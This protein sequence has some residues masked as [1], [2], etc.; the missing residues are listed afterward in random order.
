M[1]D[2]ASISAALGSAKTILDLLKNA[3]DAQLA[4]RISSEIANVQGKLIDVQQQALDLQQ[5][6]HQLRGEIERSRS[7]RQHH[8]VI[9]KLLREGE[10]DG[11]YCPACLGEGREMRLVLR[12]HVDQS[13]KHRLTRIPRRST[14]LIRAKKRRVG[15]RKKR[16]QRLRCRRAWC[17]TII[18]TEPT[19]QSRRRIFLGIR[20]LNYHP[21]IL[22][23]AVRTALS[24]KGNLP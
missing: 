12:K 15:R 9:W 11:P 3:N 21:L 18:S 4:L 13:G 10:K 23:T 20:S 19:S 24:R 17:P 5:E 7:Y 1:F 6:N 22:P 2:P 8:S 16:S 14:T